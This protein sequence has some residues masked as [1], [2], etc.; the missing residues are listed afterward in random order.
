[1]TT[2]D[3][4]NI[5]VVDDVPQKLLAM[6][7]ILHDLGQNVVMVSSG[8]EAL[9]QLLDRC[10]ELRGL[11]YV[12]ALREVEDVDVAASGAKPLDD[13]GP[14]STRTARDERDT[15]F[16]VVMVGHRLFLY[17]FFR[18]LRSESR[19]PARNEQTGARAHSGRH[20]A[21]P[22]RVAR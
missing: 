10:V 15:A 19:L 20:R 22:A 3:K 7:T 9:R 18:G 8:R 17:G 4:I 12:V 6:E 13:G 2:E 21:R 11:A 5:L 14:D 16:E 1:M